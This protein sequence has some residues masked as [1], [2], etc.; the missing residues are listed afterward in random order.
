MKVCQHLYK[1]NSRLSSTS[2]YDLT[3]SLSTSVFLKQK[4]AWAC[5]HKPFPVTTLPPGVW[6]ETMQELISQSKCSKCLVILHALIH[7][8]SCSGLWW[9][10]EHHWGGNTPWMGHPHIHSYSNTLRSH[11]AS[12]SHR[13]AWF[14][15]LSVSS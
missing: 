4:L 6:L 2:Q 13:L 14:G 8:S 3:H 1:R 5:T 12:P 15:P 11:F 10:Q 7:S 9:I